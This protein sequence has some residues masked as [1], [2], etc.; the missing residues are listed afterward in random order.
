MFDNSIVS[1]ANQ[2]TQVQETQ[3][4]VFRFDERRPFFFL[5]IQNL[6]SRCSHFAAAVLFILTFSPNKEKGKK[7]TTSE[8]LSDKIGD[9]CIANIVRFQQFHKRAINCHT[10]HSTIEK[11][12]CNSQKITGRTG[13]CSALCGSP[14]PYQACGGVVLNL[15]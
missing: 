13:S 15:T 2:N 5:F 9:I 6:V 4:E 12:A 14:V 8:W 7:N 3:Q 11:Q 10:S 1:P